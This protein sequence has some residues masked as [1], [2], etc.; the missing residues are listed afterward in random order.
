MAGLDGVSVWGGHTAEAEAAFCNPNCD[1]N[2][3]FVT[4]TPGHVA[5]ALHGLDKPLTPHARLLNLVARVT[6]RCDIVC[7]PRVNDT[8]HSSPKSR[9]SAF[10]PDV[11]PR[12]IY[13]QRSVIQ[14]RF[15]TWNSHLKILVNHVHCLKWPMPRYLWQY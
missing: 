13:N 8:H 10:N 14:L 11:N 6:C 5:D 2:A 1:I 15:C 4:S 9:H 7:K 3:D 12:A